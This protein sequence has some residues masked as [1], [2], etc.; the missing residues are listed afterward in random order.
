MRS[1]DAAVVVAIELGVPLH[2]EHESV[3]RRTHGF[4]AVVGIT[5]CLDDESVAD[6][7]Q[8][9]PMRGADG[10]SRDAIQARE[11][12]V[13][14][15]RHCVCVRRVNGRV[16]VVLRLDHAEVA[17]R[18][19]IRDVDQLQ[20]AADAENRFS[21]H[22]ERVEQGELEVVARTIERREIVR[23]TSEI[24]A[25][26]Q[27]QS[28][29]PTSVGARRRHDTRGRFGK[30]GADNESARVGEAFEQTVF[31][32]RLLADPGA[33]SRRVATEKAWRHGNACSEDVFS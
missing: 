16:A 17:K 33:A 12:S 10:P 32:E 5:G 4:D 21:N 8:G 20:A 6:A 24:G 29:A 26:L 25:A 14:A 23:R 18:P 7:R 15:E 13:C 3:G 28:V 11:A 31:E 30:A 19:P 22:A 9:L 2:A 27:Q 1:L